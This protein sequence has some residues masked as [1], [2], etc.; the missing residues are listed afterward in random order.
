MRTMGPDV[1]LA[2]HN[3]IS[4][5]LCSLARGMHC[6]P[7]FRPWSSSSCLASFTVSKN[8]SLC[9][10][11]EGWDGW[12][13][14]LKKERDHDCKISTEFVRSTVHVGECTEKQFI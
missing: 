13:L 1:L 11:L 9:D 4:P 14:S 8:F 5:G 3:S 10:N 2:R 6:F 12:S 7:G